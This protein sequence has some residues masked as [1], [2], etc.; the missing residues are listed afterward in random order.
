MSVN[1]N[2]KSI[3]NKIKNINNNYDKY[4]SLL[5]EILYNIQNLKINKDDK[6]KILD[7]LYDIDKTYFINNLNLLFVYKP[8]INY[9]NNYLYSS[10]FNKYIKCNLDNFDIKEEFMKIFNKKILNNYIVKK[11]N[12]LKEVPINFN[13]DLN[14]YKNYLL[15]ILTNFNKA[16]IYKNINNFNILNIFVKEANHLLYSYKIFNLLSY[17]ISIDNLQIVLHNAYLYYD[18]NFYKI[19]KE[20]LNV[21]VKNIDKINRLNNI[22][23]DLFNPSN[24][25]NYNIDFM[26]KDYDYLFNIIENIYFNIIS[27]IDKNIIIRGNIL[28]IHIIDILSII[29]NDYYVTYNFYIKKLK[30]IFGKCKIQIQKEDYI[31]IILYKFDIKENII[32]FSDLLDYIDIIFKDSI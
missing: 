3:I 18:L 20:I 8:S 21:Y 31:N 29:Y 19:Y 22:Y 23:I 6:I 9:T 32:K 15:L 7:M 30:D 12:E 28:I 10:C 24:L 5:E 26:N 25:Y 4:K 11:N 2:F 27:N 17:H 1:L 13:T 14:L 16:F